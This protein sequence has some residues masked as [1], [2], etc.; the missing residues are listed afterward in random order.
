MK[1]TELLV[2][3]TNEIVLKTIALLISNDNDRIIKEAAKVEDAIELFHRQ[4]FEII[5]FTSEITGEDERK[6]SKIFSIQNPDI[7]I[8]KYDNKGGHLLNDQITE[9][10]NKQLLNKKPSF[11]LVD[12]ALKNTG[13]NIVIQ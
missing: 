8:L 10:L 1:R 4:D 5:I 11:S 6:L 9:A 7:I 2:V 3:G 13:L 12:D